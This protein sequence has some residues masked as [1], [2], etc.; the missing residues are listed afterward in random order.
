M[1]CPA[2]LVISYQSSEKD[3]WYNFECGSYPQ[4]TP[5]GCSSAFLKEQRGAIKWCENYEGVGYLW[6]GGNHDPFVQ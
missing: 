6:W 4:S 3:I 5:N 1:K 2:V